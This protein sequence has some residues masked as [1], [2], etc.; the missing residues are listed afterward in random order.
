MQTN[1]FT[2]SQFN[3]E[4]N[5]SSGKKL[6][7]RTKTST[8][9]HTHRVRKKIPKE[10]IKTTSRKNENQPHNF[11]FINDS[12]LV[13]REIFFARYSRLR[14]LLLLLLLLLLPLF[15]THFEHACNNLMIHFTVSSLCNTTNQY[16][17][18]AVR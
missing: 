1:E 4:N 5:N 9:Q 13:K 7:I 8:A 16:T 3:K 17:N 11:F 14:P 10:R 2:L 18:F 15:Q 6:Y 12:W